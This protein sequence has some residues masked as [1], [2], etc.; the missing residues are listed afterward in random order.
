[1][2][3]DTYPN[4]RYNAA[5]GL[6]R[7]GDALCIPVLEEMLLPDNSLAAQD[8]RGTRDQDNKRVIVLRNG[9]QTTVVLAQKNPT[10]DLTPLKKALQTIVDSD[11]AAIKTDRGKLQIAAKEALRAVEKK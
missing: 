9:I 1:M 3:I 7:A 6:A 4:A 2:L 10:A 11:L 5:T 8:E